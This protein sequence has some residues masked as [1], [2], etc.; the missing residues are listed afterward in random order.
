MLFGNRIGVKPAA[1]I[2]L[3]CTIV[4]HSR[5]KGVF[6]SVR[7]SADRSVLRSATVIFREKS[8]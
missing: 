2:G 8:Q 6:G 3:R 7:G 4:W 1:K 5:H